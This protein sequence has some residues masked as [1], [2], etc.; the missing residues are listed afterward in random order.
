VNGRVEGDGG[1]QC[2]GSGLG[3]GP[4]RST[5]SLIV[6]HP[7]TFPGEGPARPGVERVSTEDYAPRASKAQS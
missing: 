4:V 5:A 7:V 6:D 2:S 3:S 1:R